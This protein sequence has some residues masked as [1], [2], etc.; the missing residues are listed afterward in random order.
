MFFCKCCF[1][2]LSAKDNLTEDLL[3]GAYDEWLLPKK[4][5][6]NCFVLM[7]EIFTGDPFRAVISSIT[8][9]PPVAPV[10][11]D[12]EAFLASVKTER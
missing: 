10:A 6:A 12:R 2:I 1:S 9:F 3:V 7:R 8:C 4:D 5:T 11:T